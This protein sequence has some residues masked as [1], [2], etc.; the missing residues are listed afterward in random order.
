[1]LDCVTPSNSEASA[2]LITAM[3][4]L[5]SKYSRGFGVHTPSSSP[6]PQPAGPVVLIAGTTG[7]VG[8]SF[9]SLL[10]EDETISKIYALNRKGSSGLSITERHRIIFDKQ[11]L[12]YNT[13]L[14]GLERERLVFLWVE[15]CIKCG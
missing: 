4:A 6:S 2:S 12:E 10:L 8:A 7:S 3:E 9:L 5:V 11:N 13:I 14:K 15:A 1:M